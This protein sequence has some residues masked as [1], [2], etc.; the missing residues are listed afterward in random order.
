VEN[1]AGS[2]AGGG[3]GES[4][5]QSLAGMNAFLG[6]ARRDIDGD[7]P[8]II[9][10]TSARPREGRTTVARQLAACFALAGRR[11]LLVDAREVAARMRRDRN[12]GTAAVFAAEIEKDCAPSGPVPGLWVV[13]NRLSDR[14]GD[15]SGK[16][17]GESLSALRSK[18]AA[19]GPRSFLDEWKQA[20]DVI[21]LDAAAV[22]TAAETLR[23]APCADGVVLAIRRRQSRM[24]ELSAA[25]H[26]LR[27]VGARV[28]GAVLVGTNENA[29]SSSYQLPALAAT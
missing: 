3:E 17:N 9:M 13:Q 25:L 1:A 26:Q 27:L 8:G 24:P 10:V 21:V 29:Y 2:A 20:F 11:T 4:S 19:M 28:L 12:T 23:L 22:L 6:M 15:Y 5:G 18:I 14:A 16:S 7:E